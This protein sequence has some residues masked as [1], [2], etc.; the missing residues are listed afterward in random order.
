MQLGHGIALLTPPRSAS[1]P[2]LVN[3]TPPQISFSSSQPRGYAGDTATATPGTW[4]GAPTA[5]AYQ[6]RING[7]PIP[8]ATSSSYAIPSGIPATQ[9]LTCRVTATSATGSTFSDSSP[10]PLHRTLYYKSEISSDWFGG[11]WFLESEGITESTDPATHDRVVIN[12][13]LNEGQPEGLLL[14][15]VL[16]ENAEVWLTGITC[17]QLVVQGGT[18][19]GMITVTGHALFENSAIM[20]GELSAPTATFHANSTLQGVAFITDHV[21]FSDS[22]GQNGNLTG[23]ATFGIE[24]SNNGSTE[25]SLTFQFGSYNH[26]SIIGYAA[27]YGSVS[28]SQPINGD[29][30]FNDDSINYGSITGNLELQGNAQ[31]YGDIA[32]TASVYHPSTFPMGGSAAHIYYYGYVFGCTNSSATNYDPSAN[33]DD[34]TCYYEPPPGDPP[35][36]FNAITIAGNYGSEG[37]PGLDL[38][39][40]YSSN[41]SGFYI[42]L[43]D[44]AVTEMTTLDVGYAFEVT[45]AFLGV[46]SPQTPYHLKVTAYNAYGSTDWYNGIAPYL[47]EG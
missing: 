23:N 15:H 12:Q 9:A 21:T 26:G 46:L 3:L 27:F 7:S 25:G 47:I 28:N 37:S 20:A 10:R 31:N 11:D 44:A 22:S 4:A 30:Q 45:S 42:T 41:A 38:S 34:G 39:W 36:L 5:Y 14:D 18:A 29:A 17:R 13:L 19:C 2:V 16:I 33:T 32:G 6:W 35:G 43:Y 24:C 8:G 1:G 40:E